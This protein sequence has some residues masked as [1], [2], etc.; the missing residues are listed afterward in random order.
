MQPCPPPPS[1]LPCDGDDVGRGGTI[2]LSVK[3]IERAA[4]LLEELQAY[5][6]TSIS[7]EPYTR[8]PHIR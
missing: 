6:N 1:L 2:N 7:I 8:L 5:R 3:G 4:I